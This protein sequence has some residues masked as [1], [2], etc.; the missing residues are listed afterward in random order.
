MR[1]GNSRSRYFHR[2][3]MPTCFVAVGSW[4]IPSFPVPVAVGAMRFSMCLYSW[5]G[6]QMRNILR[7]FVLANPLASCTRF[8]T[9]AVL[10]VRLVVVVSRGCPVLTRQVYHGAVPLST[11]FLKFF[12]K[13]F[14]TAKSHRY[15]PPIVPP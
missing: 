15:I 2:T 13:N 5:H 8:A 14:F 4:L 1:M 10:W 11:L 12:F 6:F 7:A 9:F 3:A